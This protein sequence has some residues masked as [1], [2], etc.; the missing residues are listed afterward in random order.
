M[1]PSV[2]GILACGWFLLVASPSPAEPSNLEAERA[3]AALGRGV[4][5][6][7][8]RDFNAAFDAFDEAV[9]LE[10][11][12]AITTGPRP[13]EQGRPRQGHRRL[14]RGHRLDPTPLRRYNNRA[15][16]YQAKGDHDKAI[17]DYTEAIRLEPENAEAFR[18]AASP[19][20]KQGR[21]RQGH[22]RLHRGHPAQPEV[23]RGLL[24]PGRRLWRARATTTRPS[25]TA[26][27]PS[28]S[29]PS[30][31]RRTS[32][33]ARLSEQGR[34]R[35]GHRRLHRGHPA[36]PEICRRLPQPGLHL[37]R[38]GPF[39]KAIAD[40]TRPFGSIRSSS[41]PTTSGASPI[42]QGRPRQGHR[43]LHGGPP[44]RPEVCRGLLQPR[45]LLP[46]QKGDP[47]QGHR[48]LH[49]GPSA[50][51]RRSLRRISTGARPTSARA[52]A[53][54]RSPT[55]PTP[56]G[57]IRRLPRRTATGAMPTRNGPIRRGHRRLHGGPPARPE[58]CRGV[59]QPGPYPH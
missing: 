16:A 8:K 37:Q 20:R 12:K 13:T 9:R 23:R 48:R 30:S 10:W 18:T 17:A 32:T 33:A 47:G 43:R 24:Q 3:K 49:R 27:R 7:A 57:S 53:T 36:Q 40:C 19:T 51:T 58:L 38:E 29:T 42:G 26:P 15:S 22:R 59:Q 54:R 44:A 50:R 21:L 4:S 39:D 41:M 1:K 2:L 56:S 52:T 5:A 14:H 46:E 31:P 25:P 28:A 35:Q 6:L 55:S 45:Q 34:L 11:P